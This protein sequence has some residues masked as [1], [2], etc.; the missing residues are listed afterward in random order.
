VT[1]LGGPLRGVQGAL[2]G[3]AVASGIFLASERFE[4]WRLQKGVQRFERKY[5]YPAP[6]IFYPNTETVIETKGPVR[7]L[8]FPSLLPK[9]I[10]VTDEEIE[11]RVQVRLQELRDEE[12]SKQA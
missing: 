9:S 3:A 4:K 10:K 8:A 12:A 7:E 6:L 2:A 1:F 5:G 11:R